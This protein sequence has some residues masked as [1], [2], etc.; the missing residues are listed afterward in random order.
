MLKGSPINLEIYVG[1]IQKVPGYPDIGA[2]GNIVLK[3]AEIIPR[4][5]S[6]KLYHDN[7]STGIHLQI[8]LGK[9]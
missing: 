6:H 3:L 8:I 5:V 2:S 1:V 4:N 9:I 7:W